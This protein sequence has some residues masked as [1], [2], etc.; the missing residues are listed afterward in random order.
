MKKVI[1]LLF[2]AMTAATVYGKTLRV[3]NATGSGAPYTTV[4]D[5]LAAA[6][7][8]DIIILESSA[9]SYGDFTI[10]KKITLQGE[11]Y[12]RIVNGISQE[13]ASTSEVGNIIV[14]A[15]GVKISSL[16]ASEITLKANKSIVTRC[17][18]VKLLLGEEYRFS[19]TPVT[20]CIIHQNYIYGYISG[21][22]Y[23]ASSENIQITNNIFA[24][25]S[26]Q[27]RIFHLNRSIV[28]RNIFRTSS[29]PLY[30]V[31]N[32]EVENNIHRGSFDTKASNT[33]V[34]NVQ[35]VFTNDEGEQYF[36]ND[37]TVKEYEESLNVDAG[38]F[39]GED[40][41]VL[42]GIAPGPRII[43][44]TVP[45]SVEQGEDLRVTVKIGNS[46]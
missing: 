9:K 27:E 38:A 45:E 3:N 24:S 11:G 12:W 5:A 34:G 4:A 41:Y 36:K 28:S 35:V 32:S 33:Y 37:K 44:L 29:N 31:N 20:D 21:D 46:K 14:K 16:S 40:P 10:E 6:S 26:Q 17:Y 7:D 25:Y 19:D 1:L 18:L 8:G 39:S 15:E 43:D 42:S 2:I 23:S 22:D 13:G 30:D